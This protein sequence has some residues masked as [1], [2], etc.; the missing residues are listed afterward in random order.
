VSD[1]AVREVVLGPEETFVALP[2]A[3][4]VD[5]RPYFLVSFDGAYRLLST[6][7]PHKGG[8][9][10]DRGD[11]FEC[12]QHGWQFDRRTG[13]CLNS[14]LNE[15]TAYP[16]EV[17]DGV[18][19][20]QLPAERRR[21]RDADAPIPE[22]L[23]FTLHAHACVEVDYRGFSLLT[24]PWIAGPAFFGAWAGYPEPLVDP[25]TLAPDAI[26]ISHE[27]SDHFHEPTLRLLPKDVPVYVPDFPNERLP[28]RLA[29]L[30]FTDVRRLPFGERREIAPEIA[31]TCLEPASLW[32]D[33]I[34][35]VEIAGFRY[36]N[37]NDAGINH[38][39]ARRV[40][41]V[42][43]MSSTFSPGA[44]GYPL[45]WQHIDDE[46]KVEIMEQ[47]RAGVLHM[48]QDAAE[49]YGARYLLPFASFFTLWHPEHRRHLGLMRRNTPRDVVEAFSDTDVEVVD[50]L[51]GE[52]WQPSTGRR[53]F[54]DDRDG[55][56]RLG[57][58]VRWV[59]DRFDE[60]AF[61]AEFPA[62]E[63]IA[64]EEVREYLVRLNEVP[65]VV[66]CE[67]LSAV[68]RGL[69]AG[70]SPDM[71]VSFEVSR[72]RLTVCDQPV[73]APNLTIEM[74]H[75]ILA[76]VIHEDVSWDEAFIGY[77]CRFDREPDVYH[78]GFWRLLQ[79]PYYRR[80]PGLAP[81][82]DGVGPDSSIAGLLDRYGAG[83]DRLMRRYGLYCLG[84]HHAPAETLRHA[85]DK[86]GLSE[87]QLERLVTE[88]RFAL[89]GEDVDALVAAHAE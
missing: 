64:E 40:A 20:A 62:D 42:D 29:T 23:R 19:V 86:H 6:V 7:C 58:I 35:L 89:V 41:P 24:D 53:T 87:A 52:S 60:E 84:C 12:P 54:R 70:G 66:A 63:R 81:T 11:V 88:L 67:D 79:A 8:R 85:A 77:W 71:E 3:V 57:S 69:D 15:L 37:V 25:A 21:R 50:L 32:N 22:G 46:R 73:E 33:A 76:R 26:W 1:E 18:V 80:S 13:R 36:L 17:R 48:L 31:L 9:V 83:A 30:G 39:V 10:G 27:H 78:A 43:L 14:P 75:G 4:E 55:L 61:A 74:P 72:G 51:A 59:K 44:S 82:V 65:D 47:A 56:F 68:L 28:V 5:G 34:V 45:T 16:A 49:S 38:R 2:A